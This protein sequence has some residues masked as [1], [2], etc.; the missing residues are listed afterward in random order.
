MATADCI[1]CIVDKY[2]TIYSTVV[3]AVALAGR[4]FTES[5]P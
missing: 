3:G 5:A 4:R 2:H 1:D